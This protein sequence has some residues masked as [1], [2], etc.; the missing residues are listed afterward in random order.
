MLSRKASTLQLEHR[1]GASR[2]T[3]QHHRTPKHVLHGH[4]VPLPALPP[5]RLLLS[6]LR[7]R[8]PHGLPGQEAHLPGVPAPRPPLRDHR[9]TVL[10]KICILSTS[11]LPSAVPRQ[12]YVPWQVDGCPSS[13][14]LNWKYFIRYTGLSGT[15]TGRMDSRIKFFQNN[16]SFGKIE[17]QN[18]F[19]PIYNIFFLSFT[20]PPPPPHTAL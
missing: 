5:R 12:P 15:G 10:T 4:Y 1:T 6:L 16:V 13:A 19:A 20:C 9:R 3:Q 2:L 18:E 7:A 11:R 8:I 17:F 14:T